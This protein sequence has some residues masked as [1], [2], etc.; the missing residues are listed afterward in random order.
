MHHLIKWPEIT[1]TE[2]AITG[3]MVI[4]DDLRDAFKRKPSI[5]RG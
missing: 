1:V 2:E 4:K 5:K 3:F